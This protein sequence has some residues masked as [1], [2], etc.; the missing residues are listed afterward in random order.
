MVKKV[1]MLIFDTLWKDD[2]RGRDIIT[3]IR[4]HN[5]TK[6]NIFWYRASP[7]YVSFLMQSLL[8]N[9]QF[10]ESHSGSKIR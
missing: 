5:Q 9:F 3:D 8:H 10:F 1:L 7:V 6:L 2:D 4:I